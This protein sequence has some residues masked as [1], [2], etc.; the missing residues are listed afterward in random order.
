MLAPC[1]ENRASVR[2]QD[3][4]AQQSQVL[5][6]GYVAV[7]KHKKPGFFQKFRAIKALKQLVR[8]KEQE[9]QEASKLAKIALAIFAGS[10]ILGV[11]SNWIPFLGYLAFGGLLAS[12]IIALI[13][14][15]NEPN[16]KSRKIARTI[17]VTTL[18]LLILAVLV[19]I[20]LVLFLLALF[21]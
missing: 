14:L 4:S 12:N 5:D 3:S 11:F 7:Q 13:V 8:E 19:A 18:I 21:G 1:S 6:G 20:L 10:L 17:L 9:G 16:R 2:M 15:L